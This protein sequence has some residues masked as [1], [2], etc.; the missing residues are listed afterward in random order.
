MDGILAQDPP[1]RPLTE[2]LEDGGTAVRSVPPEYV[3]RRCSALFSLV[4]ERRERRGDPGTA[5]M[6][7]AWSIGFATQAATLSRRDAPPDV[8]TLRQNEV[9]IGEV[10]DTLGRRLTRF[11]NLGDDPVL[12]S[13]VRSCRDLVDAMGL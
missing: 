11:F 4:A 3:A 8:A 10:R 9:A 13:D 7:R 1:L 2:Y 12:S 5:E 6:Y